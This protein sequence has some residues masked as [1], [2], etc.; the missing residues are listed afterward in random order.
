MKQPEECDF[1]ALNFSKKCFWVDNW[2]LIAAGLIIPIVSMI[3][4]HKETG[5]F[6]KEEIEVPD[7]QFEDYFILGE[8]Y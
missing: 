4:L 2:Y 1:D 8:S 6:D 3:A 5:I 7:D